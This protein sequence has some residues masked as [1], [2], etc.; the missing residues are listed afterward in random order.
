M[1]SLMEWLTLSSLLKMMSKELLKTEEV[2]YS[3]DT[4]IELGK[5]GVNSHIFLDYLQDLKEVVVEDKDGYL[6]LREEELENIWKC[7]L[8]LATSRK[9]LA[10]SSVSLEIH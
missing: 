5:L 9:A 1:D 7:L 3:E 10:K 6:D 8:S 2:D 4:I